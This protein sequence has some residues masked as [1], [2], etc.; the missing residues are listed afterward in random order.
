M[1]VT[2]MTTHDDGAITAPPGHPVPIDEAVQ[3]RLASDKLGV[4]AIAFFVVAAAA[5]MAAVVG[6]SP[7]LFASV[8]PAAPLVYVIAAL[9]IA[10]FAVGYLKM[11]RY[12]TNAGGFVAYIAKGLG[13]PWA[14]AGAGLAV[15][16]YVSLQIG[17]WSQFG[18]FAQSLV[19]DLINVDLPPLFWILVTL[20]LVTG[21]VSRGVD[22]SLL[23]LGVLIVAETLVV[24]VL[25][26][27]LVAAQGLSVFSV[28]GFTA[29]NLF[30]PGLGVSLLFAFLCFTA[31]EATVVFAEEARDP[32]RTIPRALYLV[33]AFVGVFYGLS[34][35]MIGG[36]IGTDKVQDEAAQDPAGLIF[37]LAET[38]SGHALNLAM[39]SLV[40]TSF[41]AMLLGL[42]NMFSRYLFALGRAGAMP[43][44]FA[45]VSQ[46]GTPATAAIINCVVIG[47]LLVV[48]LA[49][50]ADPILTMFAWFSGLGTA[51]F[52]AIL[53]LTSVAIV[54]FFAKNGDEH[55]PW[56]TAIAPG[57]SIVAFAY[58]GFLTWDNYSLLSG[59][60]PAAR[61]LLAL[62][63]VCL[64][65]GYLVGRM[66][67][68]ISY[69][70]QQF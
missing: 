41:I 8:G 26:V 1:K 53:L 57:A 43:R 52:M 67:P 13:T 4:V 7:V 16:C 42:A 69:D 3:P 21:L 15:L 50:G 2:V 54:V 12:I 63:P 10:L 48:A 38:T 66:K 5:P 59:T 68:S 23:V 14:S 30:G 49:G 36:A 35:W 31:F 22:A 18:V 46:F 61:W 17:L 60:S 9:M 70:A 64:F 39:Q 33:I 51:A 24:A 20:A 32:R 19:V 56:G 44:K 55:S 45:D 65:G 58:V 40:V 34:T 11:S 29:D 6:A 62:V 27:G 25:L 28:R 37:N 47:G